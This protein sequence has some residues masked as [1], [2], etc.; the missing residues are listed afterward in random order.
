M[1]RNTQG[2]SFSVALSE[3]YK[4]FISEMQSIFKSFFTIGD[5]AALILYIVLL[6]LVV[7]FIYKKRWSF[8]KYIPLS[9]VVF[10]V[11]AFVYWASVFYFRM[12]TRWDALYN[13]RVM[14]P[15]SV[16]FII[17]VLLMV[18]HNFKDILIRI[19]HKYRFLISG[20][21][22][23][24]FIYLQ[25]DNIAAIV[26]GGDLP[27]GYKEFRSEMLTELNEIPSNSHLT[28]VLYGD[29]RCS[30][31]LRHDLLVRWI[32]PSHLQRNGANMLFSRVDPSISQ[33]K[34][35]YIFSDWEQT[36]ESIIRAV[37]ERY[38]MNIDTS[39]RLVRVNWE[40]WGI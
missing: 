14:L 7:Y 21:V 28:V 10:W 18:E 8:Y 15:G 23:C 22:L 34:R 33:R 16:L 5:M 4:G 24:M 26:K 6:G 39:K 31:Y 17:G 30:V 36:P 2:E 40:D 1:P 35:V 3:M 13:L 38:M 20:V 32:Y 9:A 37:N 12:N 25:F 27:K 11:I 19:S 29:M